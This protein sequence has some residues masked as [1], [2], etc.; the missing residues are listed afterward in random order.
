[1]FKMN[2]QKIMKYIAVWMWHILAMLFLQTLLIAAILRS[3]VWIAILVFP[4]AIAEYMS[5]K[6]R[7]ELE[8]ETW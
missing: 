6:R 5:W 3:F 8:N 1:M 4:V 7:G 2:E